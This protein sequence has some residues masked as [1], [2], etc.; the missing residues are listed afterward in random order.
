M[1]KKINLSSIKAND[2]ILV[3][4]A[5]VLLAAIL[6]TA[7]YFTFKLTVSEQNS[8]DT[9]IKTAADNIE[10][11]K[12]LEAIKADKDKYNIKVSQYDEV[13]AGAN[14]YTRLGKQ[15]ELE[16]MLEKYNLTGE[17]Q[18]GTLSGYASVQMAE[19]TV[20]VVGKESDVKAMCQEI[21]SVDYIVRI[22]SFAMADN[23]DGTVTA[24]FTVVNFTK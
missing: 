2:S 23:G 8:I 9:A 5:M 6:G 22:D 4:I 24:A 14:T 21:L 12:E 20:S 7:I 16:N 11:I 18:A 3:A 15:A 19:S 1:N 13:I 17:V 10:H